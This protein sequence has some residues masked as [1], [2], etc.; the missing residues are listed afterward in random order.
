MAVDPKTP[1]TN[2]PGH[3][4][5]LRDDR[6]AWLGAGLMWVLLV[7]MIVPEGFDYV[8]LTTQDAPGSGSA[9]S[10]ALW[11]TLLACGAL[12]VLYRARLASVLLST[13]NPF[14]PLFIC[15]AVASVAWSIDPS[16]TVRRLIRLC[17]IVV[18]CAGFVLVSWHPRRYQ[19]VVRPILTIMLAGS[20]CFGLV[21]PALAIHQ[22][23]SEEL[24]G[25]WR[26]LASH[27]NGLG[28]LACIALILWLH[29]GL[30]REVRLLRAVAGGA[31]ALI[32]LALS[33]SSTSLVATA[34]VAMILLILLRAPRGL[35]PYLPHF[36][37]T[38]V[39]MLV[40]Y[41]L[42][43]LDLVPGLGTLLAPVTALTDKGTTL[44][45]RTEIWAIITEHIRLHP[46]FGSGYAA[47]WTG[48]PT[49]GTDSYEFVQRAGG[50][51]PGS[52]HNGY[53]DV[54]NDLGWVGFVCLLAYMFTYVRQSLQLAA[55]D[56]NQAALYLALY[57]QQAIANLA[58]SHW[59]SV[60]SVDFVI[61]TLATFALAR[62]LL[63]HRL[64]VMFGEP[65]LTVAAHFGA[66]A[67]PL[68]RPAPPPHH[69][70]GA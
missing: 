24:L 17:T 23:T 58:E 41:A 51:Y 27:K 13:L 65:D 69:G 38:L 55:L 48:A 64:R 31:I 7:L 66:A 30:T 32:C 59:F 42:A 44:T 16:L 36:V 67:R 34:C 40:L 11:L 18:A 2:Q 45:G 4:R 15:L 62:G 26:G 60:L 28:D 57:L 9:L 25:A 33:R 19:A 39:A 68:L 3:T 49:D 47:Y 70:A 29:A 52:A 20:I 43:E 22:E 6:H 50:F 46:F 1:N 5:W 35:R 37:V 21:F 63:D 14:L 53:L 61:M 12:I 10:R 54:V 8:T 56:R